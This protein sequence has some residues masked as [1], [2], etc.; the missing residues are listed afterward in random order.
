MDRITIVPATLA[1]WEKIVR[2]T[3]MSVNPAPVSTTAPV[4]NAPRDPPM[5]RFPAWET[6]P[7]TELLGTTVTV[8]QESQVQ[9]SGACT[10]GNKDALS[11]LEHGPQKAII[12]FSTC[13]I[14]NFIPSNEQC[15]M[16]YWVVCEWIPRK[17]EEETFIKLYYRVVCEC[18]PRKKEEETF[19]KL[20]NI[21]TH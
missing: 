7:M 1:T 6:L 15:N 17:K 19:I 9:G 14:C 12:V 13:N 16:Y 4:W 11:S 5:Y 8:S 18:I 3:S 21:F 10:S 20:I 2:R